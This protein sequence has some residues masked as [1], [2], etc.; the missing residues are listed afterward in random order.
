MK[1]IK[2]LL[3]VILAVLILGPLTALFTAMG[4]A[5]LSGLGIII[6]AA[7]TVIGALLVM[8]VAPLLGNGKS[9]GYETLQRKPVEGEANTYIDQHGQKWIKRN[10]IFKEIKE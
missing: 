8:V 4:I 9:D 1:T 10:G 7:I 6:L 2:W 3:V 5:V